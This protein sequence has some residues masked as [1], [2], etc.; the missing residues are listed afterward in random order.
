MIICDKNCT[1]DAGERLILRNSLNLEFLFIELQTN[2]LIYSERLGRGFV[3]Y[4]EAAKGG[5]YAYAQNEREINRD[6]H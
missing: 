2:C 3:V 4:C 6:Y 1:V 5:K